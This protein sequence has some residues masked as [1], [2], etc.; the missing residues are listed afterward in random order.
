LGHALVDESLVEI[1]V[2]VHAA[3]IRAHRNNEKESIAI[4]LFHPVI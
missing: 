1:V 2:A 3:T 4:R